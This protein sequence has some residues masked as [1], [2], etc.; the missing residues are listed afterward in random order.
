LCEVEKKIQNKDN[1]ALCNSMAL[2]LMVPLSIGLGTHR[3]EFSKKEFSRT[4]KSE[5]PGNMQ[6]LVNGKLVSV[7]HCVWDEWAP[8]DGECPDKC[9]PNHL[10]HQNE[11]DE[12]SLERMRLLKE[13]GNRFG[14][15]FAHNDTQKANPLKVVQRRPE[16]QVTK[17]PKVGICVEGGRSRQPIPRDCVWKN[18]SEWCYEEDSCDCPK[19]RDTSTWLPGE[20]II[21][22]RYRELKDKGNKFGK[23]FLSTDTKKENSLKMSKRKMEWEE[24]ECPSDLPNYIDP[25]AEWT[26]WGDWEDCTGP[27]NGT[28]RRLRHRKCVVVNPQKHENIGADEICQ[29]LIDFSNENGITALVEQTS[30]PSLAGPEKKVMHGS[31][32]TLKL[33]E[34]VTDREGPNGPKE[35]ELETGKNSSVTEGEKM[36]NATL[37]RGKEKFA[38]RKFVSTGRLWQ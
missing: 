12:I 24:Q 36:S 17:C 13:R 20:K 4:G 33:T 10:Y 11:T 30:C 5:S 14:T 29:S 9:A 34:V 25:H 18:W 21:R 31:S 22:E 37:Q 2:L 6:K 19:Y 32:R 23:C 3:P 28:S 15:C 35:R 27:Q 38:Y 1:M 8:W 16:K 7:K 26:K